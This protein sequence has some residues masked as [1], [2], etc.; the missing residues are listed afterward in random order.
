MSLE[1]NIKKIC[2]ELAKDLVHE[3]DKDQAMILNNLCEYILPKKQRI[4]HNT[5][6]SEA[7]DF[8]IEDYESKTNGSFKT[9]DDNSTKEVK[10]S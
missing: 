1:E 5:D 3:F 6:I 4:G 10:P 8:V 2:E 9:V 7:R